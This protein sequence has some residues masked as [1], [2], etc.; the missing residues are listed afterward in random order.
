MFKFTVSFRTVA[1]NQASLNINEFFF[2]FLF[3][4]KW[5]HLFN[6]FLADWGFPSFE[7]KKFQSG[8]GITPIVFFFLFLGW[9]W[10]ASLWMVA[11]RRRARAADW[12]GQSHPSNTLSLSVLGVFLS[13]HS[14]SVISNLFPFSFPSHPLALLCF[15]SCSLCAPRLFLPRRVEWSS[16][17]QLLSRGFPNPSFSIS[18]HTHTQ[19]KKRLPGTDLQSTFPLESGFAA[20]CGRWLCYDNTLCSQMLHECVWPHLIGP[21]LVQCK[22][23]CSLGAVNSQRTNDSLFGIQ[24]QTLHMNKSLVQH[25]AGTKR[26]SQR[27]RSGVLGSC[28]RGCRS[29]KWTEESRLCSLPGIRLSIFMDLKEVYKSLPEGVWPLSVNVC[30]ENRCRGR[31]SLALLRH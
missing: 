29:A 19:K 10:F 26:F 31:E 22:C 28:S 16:L 1:T 27:P 21:G 8:C 23:A 2:V 11:L 24:G 18:V 9:K 6:L 7:I 20:S 25:L 15:C 13:S 12:T 5:H 14:I 17:F 3:F 4:C 30:C